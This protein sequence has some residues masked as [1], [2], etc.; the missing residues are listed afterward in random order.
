MTHRDILHE[1]RAADPARK[2]DLGRVDPE[3]L[4]ALRTGVT[5]TTTPTPSAAPS[6][7]HRLS[8]RG[9]AIGVA[10]LALGG[11]IAYAGVER[12]LT[13]DGAADGITCVT[14]W[15]TA[16]RDVPDPA[17]NA[18]HVTGDPV[19]DCQERQAANGLP[20]IPDPVAFRLDTPQVY[21]A[22]RSQMP[23]GA[24]PLV[25]EPM[26]GPELE[27][28][29]SVHDLADGLGTQCLAADAAVSAARA[30]LDRL[31]LTAWS[32]SEQPA[33]A[34]AGPCARFDFVVDPLHGVATGQYHD[35]DDRTLVVVPRS[36][37]DR[38][39][40]LNDGD[41]SIVALRRGLLDRIASA[42]V[43]LPEGGRVATA[44]LEAL[45]AEPDG[46]LYANIVTVVD[47]EASCTRVDLLI[48]GG[49]EIV[50]RGPEGQ[51]P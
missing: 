42:C 3:A 39:A 45:P 34:D 8:R 51:A 37:G 49:A 28:W 31:G 15:P 7:L 2:A 5:M 23:A 41:A 20:A 30:E 36:R 24:T 19:A 40:A 32:V 11:G 13:P 27:L 10:T 43:D 9:L 16:D 25:P 14:A 50:L 47:A 46:S 6:R 33:P 35:L 48:G 18:S 17:V 29:A 4:R 22:P 12:L 38:I 21:V 26:S 1:L 44:A